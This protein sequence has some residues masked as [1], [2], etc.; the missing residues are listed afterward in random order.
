MKE[1]MLNSSF[2]KAT[3]F[4]YGSGHVRPNRAMDPGLVYDMTTTDY[5]D[6]LCSFG[7]TTAQLAMFNGEPY[8][9][10]S[11][12]LQIGDLN[13]PSITI[14]ELQSSTKVTR[15]VKNVG[16]PGTYVVR[17]VEPRGV[18]ITVS[19]ESLTFGKVGEEKRFE[20]TVGIKEGKTD[21]GGY[22]FGRL[23]WSDGKHYVTSPAVV[24]CSS[25][26]WKP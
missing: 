26:S 12:P 8:A 21:C 1:P 9:C 11:T 15:V 5:M 2:N 16:P 18:S 22:V 24:K 19:P 7:Y 17:V 13:Y 10:P 25:S 20:V 6:F 4:G 23:I 14:P 3:P